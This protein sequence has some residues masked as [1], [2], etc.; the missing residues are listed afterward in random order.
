MYT[1]VPG[2]PTAV[3]AASGGPATRPPRRHWSGPHVIQAESRPKSGRVPKAGIAR[4]PRWRWCGRRRHLPT[5]G[6]RQW[7]VSCVPSFSMAARYAAGFIPISS[8]SS[9]ARRR[10]AH[11]GAPDDPRGP[12]GARV[13]G[14][15]AAE[16]RLRHR[17]RCR[18]GAAALGAASRRRRW[19][20]WSAG[21]PRPGGARTGPRTGAR[22]A[23][24]SAPAGRSIPP[25]RATRPTGP[26]RSTRRGPSSSSPQTLAPQRR[27]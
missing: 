9:S 10:R 13:V 7:V 16:H 2:R 18:R 26:G 20:W 11:G 15:A 25:S 24:W 4:C 14:T 3:P 19:R 8:R 12:S 21:Q 23:D 5:D 27:V 17:T 1:H 6:D 22:S